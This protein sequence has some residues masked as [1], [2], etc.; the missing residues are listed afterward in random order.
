MKAIDRLMRAYG[1]TR[2]LTDE[3]ADLVR[4]ELSKFIDQLMLGESSHPSNGNDD[5]PLKPR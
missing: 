5:G 4:R 3:Q 2:Q 1:L